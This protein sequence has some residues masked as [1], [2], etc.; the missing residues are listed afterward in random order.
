MGDNGTQCA[1]TV[2]L[3]ECVPTS[4][5]Y[6]GQ[7][8][9]TPK[10]RFSGHWS[11]RGRNSP[12]ALAMRRHGAHSFRM[13]ILDTVSSQAAARLLESHHIER[14][15][16]QWPYGL[17]MTNG[18]ANDLW[19]LGMTR[20]CAM[21]VGND[22]RYAHAVV[23]Y[24]KTN[25]LNYWLPEITQRPG[26][27]LTLDPTVDHALD[28][29]MLRSHLATID[30]AIDVAKDYNGKAYRSEARRRSGR[31]KWD[32]P[33]REVSGHA[34]R[35]AALTQCGQQKDDSVRWPY[36]ASMPTAYCASLIGSMCA[37]EA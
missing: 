16:T 3:I 4:M 18:A 1:A 25:T 37:Q 11:D 8:R 10:E 22:R 31:E 5:A 28:N 26:F 17:N 24:K 33:R 32:E 9:R 29:W 14:L 6:V 15:R 30:V 7:T 19:H 20:G 2:Y 35:M 34:E 12:L 36:Y 13:S 23:D 27:M 21:F